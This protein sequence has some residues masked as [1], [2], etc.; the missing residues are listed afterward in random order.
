VYRRLGGKKGVL[1]EQR[2][3]FC[4]EE[5]ET[6]IVNWKQDFLVHHRMESAVKR[7]VCYRYGVIEF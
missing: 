7:E 1:Y 5:K 3:T 4:S 6:G 2:I